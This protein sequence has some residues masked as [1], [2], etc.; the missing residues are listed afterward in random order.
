MLQK[1]HIFSAIIL[2]LALALAGVTWSLISGTLVEI[3]FSKKKTVTQK[4]L[5][6]RLRKEPFWP[7]FSLSIF[8]READQKRWAVWAGAIWWWFTLLV[9]LAEAALQSVDSCCPPFSAPESLRRG[10]LRR[11]GWRLRP[12]R[13]IPLWIPHIGRTRGTVTLSAA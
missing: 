13:L 3:G 12:L 11:Y 10:W 8:L 9:T 7:R 6:R 5:R 4:R 1:Q 2:V